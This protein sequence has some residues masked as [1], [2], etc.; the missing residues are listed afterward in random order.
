MILTVGFWSSSLLPL[1]A[2]ITG[3]HCSVR[4]AVNDGITGVNCHVSCAVSAGITSVH[5]HVRYVM[6]AGITGVHCSVSYAVQRVDCERQALCSTP[7]K[8]LFSFSFF[9]TKAFYLCFTFKKK[10][11]RIFPPV[12]FCLASS[13]S[14][15]PAEVVSTM[16]PNCRDGSRLFCHF[17]R[18]LSW[19]SNLGLITPHLFNLLVRF[20]T[21]FPALWSSMISNSPMY[22][23][24]IITVKNRKMTLEQ[25][26]MR[27]WRLPFFSALLML[28]RASARTFIR[29]MVAVRED[30]RKSSFSFDDCNSG[31]FFLF[32]F[33]HLCLLLSPW[34]GL[35]QRLNNFSMNQVYILLFP[36]ENY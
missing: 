16:K 20:T 2:G 24:F 29:T 26:L 4:Y 11:P 28:L 31:F 33:D 36:L 3:V 22:P 12:C 19:T 6:S 14:M 21:I 15:M 23:C 9:S 7:R 34:S 35:I 1:D 10:N 25:D 13:W 8:G 30:G 5:C 17:S 27:I 32:L 18:S